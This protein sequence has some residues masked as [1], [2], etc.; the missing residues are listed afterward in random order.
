MLVFLT[1]NYVNQTLQPSLCHSLMT[2]TSCE[3]GHVILT[4]TRVPILLSEYLNSLMSTHRVLIFVSAL[5]QL[6]NPLVS[7]M[8]VQI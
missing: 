6:I 2:N 3:L 5:V 1:K 8:Y 7:Y 4:S